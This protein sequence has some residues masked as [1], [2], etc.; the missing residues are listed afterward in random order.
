ML[1]DYVVKG[2]LGDRVNL[3]YVKSSDQVAAIKCFAKSKIDDD[4]FQY[5]L[6]EKR[7]RKHTC[8][9]RADTILK[10]I[11]LTSTSQYIPKLLSTFET[12]DTF[13]MALQFIPGGDMY[14]HLSTNDAMMSNGDGIRF[15]AAQICQAIRYLHS[16]SVIY[17]NLKPESVMICQRGDIKLID[18]SISKV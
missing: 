13:Y 5:V 18:F 2:K 6:V 4:N 9:N 14:Y 17:R 11:L 10:K 16:M 12:D 15:Y 8:V 3:A 7:V 1:S